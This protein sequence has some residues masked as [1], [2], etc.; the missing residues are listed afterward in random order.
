METLNQRV[1][2]EL[3][4]DGAISFANAYYGVPE[5]GLSHELPP[6]PESI[7]TF[8]DTNMLYNVTVSGGGS[9]VLEQHAHN[10]TLK[11]DC[12]FF[13]SYLCNI[14]FVFAAI[15]LTLCFLFYFCS[16]DEYNNGKT[17]PA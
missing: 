3:N 12:D 15:L 8:S 13:P 17:P 2:V 5:A 9:C 16:G 1:A 11:L 7:S 6:M 4:N 14:D 10:C